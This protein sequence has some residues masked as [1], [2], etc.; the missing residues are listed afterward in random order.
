LKELIEYIA[1]AI[2]ENPDAVKV[3]EETGP[4]RIDLA[5]EVAPE[6]KGTIIGKRGRVAQAMRTVLRVAAI[7]KGVRAN[8]EI[9]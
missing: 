9:V 5:L 7:K 1:K 6:D 8:L 2:S 3:T 4:D